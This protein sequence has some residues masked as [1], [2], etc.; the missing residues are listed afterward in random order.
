MLKKACPLLLIIVL[1]LETKSNFYTDEI[2]DYSWR[3]VH[4]LMETLKSKAGV[5]AAYINNEII[6]T[7]PP[8]KYYFRFISLVGYTL[9][10]A[11]MNKIYLLQAKLF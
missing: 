4:V 10:M 11:W 6:S 8:K 3:S 9:Y 7:P 5:D 2:S 1:V